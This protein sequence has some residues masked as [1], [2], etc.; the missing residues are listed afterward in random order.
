MRE[1]R[2]LLKREES[3]GIHALL[4][5]SE[6]P[7]ISTPEI[8]QQLEIPPA[9][10]AK[11]IAKLSKAG[12]LESQLGRN[13]GIHLRAD[14][15]QISLLSVMEAL[16]GQVVMDTCQLKPQCAT[17]ERRGRCRLKPVWL[18]TSLALRALLEGVK[19]A[20]LRGSI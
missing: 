17:E 7:G 3:Y 13:G 15:S 12:L 8:A 4:A 1:L 2:T 6:A 14:P 19:L 5:V 18:E 10:L 11:V 9:F 20:G 16:S